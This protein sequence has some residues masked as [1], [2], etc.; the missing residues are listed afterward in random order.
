MTT[1]PLPYQREDLDRIDDFDGRALLG[2][3][4]GLGKTP[5]S[6]YWANR[7]KTAGS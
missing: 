6:L 4:M 3:E 7:N 1:K 2:Y 5:T